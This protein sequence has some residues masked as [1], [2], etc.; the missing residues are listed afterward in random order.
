M[1][2]INKLSRVFGIDSAR[3]SVAVL[4]IRL[5]LKH[6]INVNSTNDDGRS[7]LH[8]VAIYGRGSKTAG[9]VTD[10]LLSAG[11]SYTIKDED[12]KTPLELAVKHRSWTVF[13]RMQQNS[14]GNDAASGIKLTVKKR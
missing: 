4:V 7:A 8:F 10:L 12:G 3:E 1:D 5:L 13:K 9:K 6:G 14:A 2:T 11:A